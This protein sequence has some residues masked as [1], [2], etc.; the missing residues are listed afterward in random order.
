MGEVNLSVTSPDKKAKAHFVLG[1]K[2]LHAFMYELAREQFQLAQKHDPFFVMA[3]WGE[4]MTHKQSLWNKDD[5]KGASLVLSKMPKEIETCSE[6][7]KGLIRGAFLL[8]SPKTPLKKRD[9]AY[10]LQLKKLY[11]QSPG[12][13]EIGAFY[14][15]SL[16][17]WVADFPNEKDAATRILIARRILDKLFKIYPKHVGVMHYLMHAYDSPDKRDAKNALKAAD[18]SLVLVSSSSHMTHMSAHIYRRLEMWPDF[19]RANLISVKASEKLCYEWAVLKKDEKT[20]KNLELCNADN[21]YHSLE[22]LQYGYL[23]HGEKKKAA[24]VLARTQNTA[25]KTNKLEFK[26]WYYRLFARQILMGEDF[27]HDLIEIEPISD[28]GDKFWSIYSECGAVLANGILAVKRQ[29]P[30]ALQTSLKRLSA[31]IDLSKTLDPPFIKKTCQMHLAAL[32][33]SIALNAHQ[34]QKA[35]RYLE[36]GYRIE[37]ANPSSEVTPSLV[38]ITMREFE[39]MIRKS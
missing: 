9:E 27:K 12:N 31:L 18:S 37:K 32:N 1:L 5:V 19:V 14:A 17:Q 13:V 39:K 25:L 3:Y 2:F 38:F 28:K 23:L 8:F 4:A 6:I 29:H 22:W 16:M 15:L 11:Q 7:E 33:A 26:Q 30:K 36:K 35:N 20:L 21:K 24:S 10:A 34:Y